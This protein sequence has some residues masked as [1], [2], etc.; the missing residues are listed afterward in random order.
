MLFQCI[1]LHN[2]GVYN[3]GGNAAAGVVC[4]INTN[5]SHIIATVKPT[6]AGLSNTYIAILSGSVGTAVIAIGL[7]IITII[8]FIQRMKKKR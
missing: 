7:T 1:N 4:L 6:S 8:A 5:S 2:I 3:C